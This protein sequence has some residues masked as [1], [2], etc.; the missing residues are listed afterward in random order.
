MVRMHVHSY[1]MNDG[2]EVIFRRPANVSPEQETLVQLFDDLRDLLAANRIGA[3]YAIGLMRRL[4]IG[5]EEE[6][7]W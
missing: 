7:R 3:V 4:S 5:E 2:T 6:I 1:V